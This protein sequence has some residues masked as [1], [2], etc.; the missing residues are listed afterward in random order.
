M[1]TKSIEE[2]V[3]RYYLD[4]VC[5]KPFR[6]EDALRNIATEQ[7]RISR[8]EERDRCIKAMQDY[9]CKIKCSFYKDCKCEIAEDLVMS[10]TTCL[11]HS[12]IRKAIEEGGGEE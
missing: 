6:V 4:W 10:T 12:R 1:A 9:Y 11:F 3:L 2:R 5:G 8:Q 7:D